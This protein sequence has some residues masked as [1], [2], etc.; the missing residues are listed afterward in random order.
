MPAAAVAVVAVAARA[1]DATRGPLPPTL[2]GP[3]PLPI[4]DGAGAVVLLWNLAGVL[5][6][7]A[8]AVGVAAAPGL[9]AAAPLVVLAC[10]LTARRRL[11]R[12]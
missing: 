12:A 7:G 3:V 1:M 9:V 5:V 11:A 2:L 6:T 10:L 4:G 8:S